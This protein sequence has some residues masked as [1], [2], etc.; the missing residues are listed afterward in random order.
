MQILIA[1]SGKLN[2][3]RIK[4]FEVYRYYTDTAELKIREETLNH[5]KDA[6]SRV[7]T[8]YCWKTLGRFKYEDFWNDRISHKKL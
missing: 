1:F 3:G 2:W 6:K 7:Y 8:L 4:I 5:Q